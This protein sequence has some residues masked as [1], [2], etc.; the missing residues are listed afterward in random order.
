MTPKDNSDGEDLDRSVC[1]TCGRSDF[2]DL[3]AMT[4]HHALTHS[5]RYEDRFWHQVDVRDESD[6]WLWQGHVGQDGYG[7]IMRNGDIKRSHREAYRLDNDG[8]AE[9]VVCHH[10]DTPLCVNPEHLY[11]GTPTSNAQDASERGQLSMGEDHY[12]SKVTEEDVRDI[13]RRY[14]EEDITQPELA[15]EYGLSRQAISK[16]TRRVS[17]KGIEP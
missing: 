1:P 10:C 2:D 6:C 17:W 8:V 15:D 4:V 3:R 16:I 11:D 13:R 9:G 12:E 7:Q 14:E 5:D